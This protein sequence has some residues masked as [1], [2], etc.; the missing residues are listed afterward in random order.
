[1]AG[2]A[3]ARAAGRG[4]AGGLQALL[5]PWEPPA[6]AGAAAR[7]ALGGAPGVD[8]YRVGSS[9]N[10]RWHRGE[11]SRG[12]REARLGQRG[13]VLWLTGLSGS[14]KSTVAYAA[15]RALHDAGREVVVLDG[16][17]VRHGLNCNLGFAP[18]DRE[19]NVR[20]L[21]E[22]AKL[23]AEQGVIALV[24]LIS[25]YRGDRDKVRARLGEGEFVEVFM[26]IPLEVCEERDPKGLYKAVRAG[27]IKGFTGVDAPYEEPL[28]PEITVTAQNESGERTSVED[29]ATQIVQYLGSKGYLHSPVRPGEW[30][31][32]D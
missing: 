22:V 12:E 6:L 20:R 11:V 24:S 30:I 16:D 2:A 23:F 8:A 13:C 27:K 7:R 28:E 1:M 32:T 10:V 26:K 4:G 25:P 17:N 5:R 29:M 21:G 18:E 31:K 3:A 14:G 19:E 9:T 15:E